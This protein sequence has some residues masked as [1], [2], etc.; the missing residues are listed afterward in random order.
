MTNHQPQFGII[1]GLL[2]LQGNA[3]Y[4]SKS[5]RV[6]VAGSS[7]INNLTTVYI[8]TDNGYVIQVSQHFRKLFFKDFTARARNGFL[9]FD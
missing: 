8:G 1:V 4:S 5:H 7:T 6:T 3:V 9:V 2:P